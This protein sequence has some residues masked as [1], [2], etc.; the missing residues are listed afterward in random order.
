MTPPKEGAK[1]PNMPRASY[2]STLTSGESR[3]L[4]YVA[5]LLPAFLI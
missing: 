2:L 4:R 5:T 1:L 3:L